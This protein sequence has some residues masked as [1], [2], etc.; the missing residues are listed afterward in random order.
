M[1][2]GWNIKEKIYL[3]HKIFTTLL[4]KFLIFL[5]I[6]S[7]IHA[8]LATFNTRQSQD[9]FEKRIFQKILTWHFATAAMVN[10]EELAVLAR[11]VTMK[12]ISLALIP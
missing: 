7:Q 5:F 12:I 8:M 6:L 11:W 9:D 2:V 4:I 10:M 1:S 3:W